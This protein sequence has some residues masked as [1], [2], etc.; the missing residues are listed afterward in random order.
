[1]IE[2]YYNPSKKLVKSCC[3]FRLEQP[4]PLKAEEGV[5]SG[6]NMVEHVDANNPPYLGEALSEFNIVFGGGRVTGGVVVGH[7]DRSG[8]GGDSFLKDLARMDDA[9]VQAADGNLADL[10]KLIA[11]VQEQR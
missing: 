9:R 5:V 2:P 3:Q 11:G 1:M 4:R 10:D 7:N 6:D 8:A